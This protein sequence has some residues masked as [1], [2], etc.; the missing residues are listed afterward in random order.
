MTKEDFLAGLK[1]AI[2][3][4]NDPYGEFN[5]FVSE[6]R[7]LAA[8]FASHDPV[9]SDKVSAVLRSIED[10]GTYIRSRVERG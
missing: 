9:L 10:I 4:M 7:E 1:D 5:T 2:E 6:G 8:E 3:D